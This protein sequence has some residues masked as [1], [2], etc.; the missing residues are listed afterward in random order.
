[1]DLRGDRD[2]SWD[3]PGRERDGH[4]PQGSVPSPPP[5]CRLQGRARLLGGLRCR[6]TL[7]GQEIQE[8]SSWRVGHGSPRGR[9]DGGGAER[10]KEPPRPPAEALLPGLPDAGEGGR[11]REGLQQGREPSCPQGRAAPG[12]RARDGVGECATPALPGRAVPRRQHPVPK[13]QQ[14][15]VRSRTAGGAKHSQ[16]ALALQLLPLRPTAAALRCAREEIQV[17]R[18]AVPFLRERLC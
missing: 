12:L 6:E 13:V 18:P 11:V 10:S 16:H 9:C 17:H 14:Q 15:R 8:G 1:M 7:C 5:P 4:W 3:P 2:R